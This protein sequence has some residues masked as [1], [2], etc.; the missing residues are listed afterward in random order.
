MS[1]VAQAPQ[2]RFPEFSGEW[3]EKKLDSVVS[4]FIVPMRD[5]PTDLTG[6]YRGVGLKILM[7][8]ISINQKLDKVCQKKQ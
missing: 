3:K 1:E 4:K 7:V 5:K 2:L 8:C 6:L